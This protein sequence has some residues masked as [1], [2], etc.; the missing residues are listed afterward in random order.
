MENKVT[1]DRFQLIL[2]MLGGGVYGLL[3]GILLACRNG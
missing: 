3:A 1:L 2:V